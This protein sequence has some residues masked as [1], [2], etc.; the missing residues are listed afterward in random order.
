MDES[1]KRP[2]SSG[3]SKW[4][5]LGDL[6]SSPRKVS[7]NPMIDSYRPSDSVKR[8]TTDRGV[9]LAIDSYRPGSSGRTSRPIPRAL[10]N[11]PA[12]MSNSDT[13]DR[14]VA[15]GSSGHLDRS[16]G[17]SNPGL[18]LSASVSNLYTYIFQEKVMEKKAIALGIRREFFQYLQKKRGSYARVPFF[19]S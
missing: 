12:N 18:N 10:V 17:M 1:H 3:G 9:P 4:V 15:I 5:K 7:T 6:G 16:T 13:S 19:L 2:G 14:S 11:R 8:T